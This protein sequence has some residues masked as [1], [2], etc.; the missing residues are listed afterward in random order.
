MI[1]N[2]LFSLVEC[3]FVH[4]P[5]MIKRPDPVAPN[6]SGH[7]QVLTTDRAVKCGLA[8]VVDAFGVENVSARCLPYFLSLLKIQ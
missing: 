6:N 7:F 2:S 5:L 4:Q 8:P 3:S 1:K